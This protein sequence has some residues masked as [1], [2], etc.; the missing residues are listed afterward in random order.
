MA[1][2]ALRTGMPCCLAPG[3]LGVQEAPGCTG[4]GGAWR[5]RA[6]ENTA[7]SEAQLCLASR[8]TGVS[9]D[10]LANFAWLSTLPLAAAR[11]E[12]SRS[13]QTLAPETLEKL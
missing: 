3:E 2:H 6:S 10:S 11:P 7:H 1:V 5:L 13:S 9:Q 12:G 8:D 4:A